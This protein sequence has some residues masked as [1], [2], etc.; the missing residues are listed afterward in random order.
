[1]PNSNNYLAYD[2]K[3]YSLFID[4]EEIPELLIQGYEK[5]PNNWWQKARFI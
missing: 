1:M 5:I 3:G 2:G 4:K